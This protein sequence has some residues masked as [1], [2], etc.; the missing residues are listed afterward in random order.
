MAYIW[1]KKD[2]KEPKYKAVLFW[3]VVLGLVLVSFL[4]NN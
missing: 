4:G 1:S 3:V 2:W